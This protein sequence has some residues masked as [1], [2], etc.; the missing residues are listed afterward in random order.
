MHLRPFFEN[1]FWIKCH[2]YQWF[3]VKSLELKK[4]HMQVFIKWP[5]Q[6]KK[7]IILLTLVLRLWPKSFIFGIAFLNKRNVFIRRI[8]TLSLFLI[9]RGNPHPELAC[10]CW[11]KSLLRRYCCL[12]SIML[13][14][15]MP[16]AKLC[17]YDHSY[18]VKV[19]CEQN[20]WI[21]SLCIII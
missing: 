1:W 14:I 8:S 17:L 15:C 3:L 12:V 13:V 9:L 20:V 11:K 21:W 7:C 19:Y 2:Q 10:F 5:A 18:L 6:E 4:S 16:W